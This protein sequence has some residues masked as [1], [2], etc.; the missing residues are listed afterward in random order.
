MAE[1]KTQAKANTFSNIRKK[2][3][4][5]FNSSL[6]YEMNALRTF[7]ETA[8]KK[9]GPDRYTTKHSKDCFDCSPFLNRSIFHRYLL[10]PFSESS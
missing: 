10:I 2:C 1:R 8:L 6:L 7:A 3:D 4:V 5:M 9:I